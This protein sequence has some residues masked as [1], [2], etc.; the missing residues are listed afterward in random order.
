MR[1]LS[2]KKFRDFDGFKSM[3]VRN[4]IHLIFDKTEIKCTSDHRFRRDD[5]VWVEA[6]NMVKGDSFNGYIFERIIDLNIATEVYD[7]INVDE[8]SSFYAEGLNAHNCSL[9]YI[10]EC[11][12]IDNWQEFS[13]S[14]LPTISSGKTT[15]LLY[16]STPNGLNHFYKACE[17][18]KKTNTKEWNGFH[19]I[20]VPWW[21]VPGRDE[22]WKNEVLAEMDFDYEKF[23]QEYENQFLGSSGT[24]IEGNKIK[25]LVYKTPIKSVNNIKMYEEPDPDRK[26]VCI[27]DVSRGKGLDYSAFQIIDVTEMPYRQVCVYKDNLVTPVEYAEIIHGVG[28][29]YNNCVILVEVNDIGAQVS[30]LLHFDYEYENILMTESA[31]RSGKQITMGFGKKGIDRGIRTT[32]TVKSIGCSMLKLLIEQDQ[33]IINDFDTI[34][35]LSTFSRKGNSYEAE[36]GT[37][38]DLVMCLVLFS[39]LSDQRYFHDLTDVNTLAHLRNKSEEDLMEELLPFGIIDDGLDNDTN[40]TFFF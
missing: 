6:G 27:V 38:D 35:E 13:A 31:G 3:G 17:G 9:L 37:H 39:W 5:G 4:I 30:D 33:L 2:N 7:A 34:S 32:K 19:I 29:M 12:F 10:D 8:T 25:N 40:N 28:K 24:L 18:A 21:K 1:I 36:Q 11:A 14:V 22:A 23:S 15:K 20:E 16:T 26:Y